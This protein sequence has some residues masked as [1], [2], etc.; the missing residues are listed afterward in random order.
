M[1]KINIL[2]VLDYLSINEV[3]TQ[4]S[5]LSDMFIDQGYNVICIT[6]FDD[7]K[8]SVNP[9]IKFIRLGQQREFIKLSN[10]NINEIL[11]DVIDNEERLLN[12]KFNLILVNQCRSFKQMTSYSNINNNVYYYI[13]EQVKGCEAQKKHN[14]ITS[15]NHLY[16]TLRTSSPDANIR[17][18]NLPIYDKWFNKKSKRLN[19]IPDKY[20][21][22]TGKYDLNNSSVL[23]IYK[24]TKQNIPLVLIGWK[25]IDHFKKVYTKLN[26]RNNVQILNKILWPYHIIKNAQCGIKTNE[27]SI[28]SYNILEYLYYKLP[29]I[30]QDNKGN[31]EIL[32]EYIPECL[33]PFNDID[34]FAQKLNNYNLFKVPDNILDKF[35]QKLILKQYEGLFI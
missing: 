16:N 15:A 4:F 25:Y 7:I 13:T 31:R 32:S 20:I 24:H 5:I 27:H 30:C 26:L 8:I 14:I 12:C 23:N 10:V 33:V 17:H 28:Q 2:F 29:I 6:L 22:Q 35:N 21:L 34:Q 1:K 19:Y 9:K 3:S 18:I 11:I